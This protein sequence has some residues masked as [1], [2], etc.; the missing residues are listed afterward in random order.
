MAE[1]DHLARECGLTAAALPALFL[2]LTTAGV[3][4]HWNAA[5]MTGDL[6]WVLKERAR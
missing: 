5:A 3:V 6:H 2:Q 4:S 1:P